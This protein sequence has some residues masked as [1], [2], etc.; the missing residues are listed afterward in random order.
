MKNLFI[1][2]FLFLF[3]FLIFSA[4]GKQ[5]MRL[6]EIKQSIKKIECILN[7]I[8]NF[9]MGK[10]ELKKT[11]NVDVLKNPKTIQKPGISYVGKCSHF[12]INKKAAINPT[13]KYYIAMRW[14]YNALQKHWNLKN[15]DEVKKKIANSKFRIINP[16]NNKELVVKAGDWGPAAHTKRLVDLDPK[17]MNVLECNTDDEVKVV[18]HDDMEN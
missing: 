13:A 9:E 5:V 17:I 2:V 16:K 6:S 14:D 15:K 7:P 4:E 18:F 3:C 1:I 11:E 10:V 12:K 8:P